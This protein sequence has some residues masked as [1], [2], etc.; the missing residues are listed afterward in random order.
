MDSEKFFDNLL[1]NIKSKN[2]PCS[3]LP[4]YRGFNL[5]GNFSVARP[6]EAFNFFINIVHIEDTDAIIIGG[7]EYHAANFILKDKPVYYFIKMCIIR[8]LL[9]VVH[10]LTR[11]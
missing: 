9:H 11:N 8:A 1:G 6:L 7:I 5:L 10:F 4:A 3:N 2:A